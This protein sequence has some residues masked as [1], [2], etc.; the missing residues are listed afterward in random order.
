VQANSRWT[1]L[2][3]TCLSTAAKKNTKNRT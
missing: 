2:G 1:L 3:R